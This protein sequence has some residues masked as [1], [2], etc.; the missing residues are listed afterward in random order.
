ML[1]RVDLEGANKHR[2]SSRGGE[3]CLDKNSV[4][5][6]AINRWHLYSTSAWGFIH[7]P[8]QLLGAEGKGVLPRN[9]GDEW[10]GTGEHWE[11]RPSSRGA[12]LQAS[13][14]HPKMHFPPIQP[15]LA[16]LQTA[17]PITPCNMVNLGSANP[18]RVPS[19]PCAPFQQRER[20]TSFKDL[21]SS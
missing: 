9:G 1:A 21:P 14:T 2:C 7:S 13:S 20:D 18:P 19:P 8:G 16:T 4:L 5:R 11:E 15:L 17:G 12:A 10:P 6:C 3:G